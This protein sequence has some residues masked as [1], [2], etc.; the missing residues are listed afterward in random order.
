MHFLT[1]NKHLAKYRGGSI[2]NESEHRR[3]LD[4]P[5]F[6]IHPRWHFTRRHETG[7][8]VEMSGSKITLLDGVL[9]RGGFTLSLLRCLDDEEID[10]VLR[11]IHE[12]ICGNH[13]GAR[14]LAFNA[15]R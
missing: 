12:R 8:K 6:L 15:L 10:Y 5:N 14:T 4:G 11:E 3:I 13:S 2:S 1:L 7:K 9:Y